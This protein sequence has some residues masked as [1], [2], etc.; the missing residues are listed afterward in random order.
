MTGRKGIVCAGTWILD[1]VHDVERWPEKSDLVHIRDQTA[2]VGG[3][4]ANVAVDLATLGAPYPVIPVGL[5]G[6]DAMGEEVLQ[7][8]HR[9]G[10]STGRI[11][12]TSQAAT[13]HTHVMNVPGDS[14]TF[15]YHPGANDLLEQE[16][17]DVEDLAAGGAKV[18]YLGY[19]NLLARL[20]RIGADGRTGAAQLLSRAREAGMLACL[21]LVSSQ[22]QEYR[23]RVEAT[24]PDVDVLFLNEVEAARSTGIDI[25]GPGDETAMA[26]AAKALIDCGVRHSVILHSAEVTIWQGASGARVFRPETVPAERIV[27]PVGAGDAF[28]AGILHGFHEEWDAERAIALAFRAA[29]AC[30]GGRTATDGLE[31]LRGLLADQTAV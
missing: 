31:T 5:I 24:L 19:L 28:A 29:A 4:P 20:D 12:R 17:I 7:L 23:D 1:V 16:M 15:F 11:A 25:S 30:L 8:C 22:A 27:S 3:G 10:L 21:D 6:E 18:F 13:A 9:A 26:S 2:G 14:R